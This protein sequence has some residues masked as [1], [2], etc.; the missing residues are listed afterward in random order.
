MVANDL[1]CPNAPSVMVIDSIQ[2][3][4]VPE[5]EG[6][7]GT[8]AQIRASV[9]EII[10]AAKQNDVAV[11][12]VGHVTKEGAIAGPKLVEHAVD[13]VLYFEGERSHQYRILRSTKNRFGATD[14]IGVFEMSDRGLAE[15]ANPSQIFLSDRQEDIAGSVVFP[16]IEGTRPILVEIQALVSPTS[17]GSP[18][19]TVV[20]WDSGRLAMILAVLEA[21]LG[22]SFGMH[23]VYLNVVG[24]FRITEPAADLA[25]ATAL[26][27][28]ISGT[29]IPSDTVVF[30]EIGLGGE[31]RPVGQTE[32]RLKEAAKLGF[33]NAYLPRFVRSGKGAANPIAKSVSVNLISELA[34]LFAD[35]LRQFSGDEAKRPRAVRSA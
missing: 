8:V 11:F 9:A 29:P 31:V 22:I 32:Q 35:D 34:P 26:M 19:R 12:L 10:Q 3:M 15:V 23:D 28:S 24:G 17:Y 4:C 20:G 2:T 21:R 27:S 5:L 1:A 6:A 25:V 13:C 14:E 18:R 16:G 30:G 33:G 7:A